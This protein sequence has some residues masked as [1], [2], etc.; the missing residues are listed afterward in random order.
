MI[1]GITTLF[2]KLMQTK[3]MHLIIENLIQFSANLAIKTYNTYPQTSASLLRQFLPYNLKQLIKYREDLVR[4]ICTK[5]FSTYLDYLKRVK[6]L[7]HTLDGKDDLILQD[8]YFD[9][10]PDV[11]CVFWEQDYPH[12]QNEFKKRKGKIAGS[13]PCGVARFASILFQDNVMQNV[14]NGLPSMAKTQKILF[15]AFIKEY[16]LCREDN[17]RLWPIYLNMDYVYL[18]ETEKRKQ[19]SAK[20]LTIKEMG[21]NI[22]QS[23]MAGSAPIVLKIFQQLSTAYKTDGEIDIAEMTNSVLASVPGQT[24]KEWDI[25]KDRTN[26]SV[27]QLFENLNWN[28]L[29]SASLGETYQMKDKPVIVKLIKPISLYFMC[30]EVNHILTSFWKHTKIY[31]NNDNQQTIVTR[32]LLLFLVKEIVKEFDFQLE[33]EATTI[34]RK[35]YNHAEMGVSTS[36]AISYNNLDMGILELSKVPGITVSNL[37]SVLSSNDTDIW[38]SLRESISNFVSL[39]YEHALFGKGWFHADPHMGNL[40]FDPTKKR[41]YVIDFGATAYIRDEDRCNMIDSILLS[42][43]IKKIPLETTDE[44]YKRKHESNVKTLKKLGKMLINTCHIRTVFT[45]ELE[46][47]WINMCLVYGENMNFNFGTFLLYLIEVTVDGGVCISDSIVYLGKAIVYLTD[48]MFKFNQRK[49]STVPAIVAEDT[50]VKFISIPS[51]F[52]FKAIGKYC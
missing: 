50:V 13:I 47:K 4:H 7:A 19:A 44:E 42:T 20:P 46:E 49:P 31:S 18:D 38:S 43:N 51:F 32:K 25:V 52:K 12:L 26:D 8:D 34:A 10:F 35:L 37:F 1:D 14:F 11:S 29:G 22:V 3:T 41:L 33:F 27:S 30:C 28:M 48:L 40:L 39:W 16:F 17:V 9:Q 45:P 6:E 23:V 5:K 36:R 15:E 24:K 21:I 2:G